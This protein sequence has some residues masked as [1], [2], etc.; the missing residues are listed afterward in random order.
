MEPKFKVEFLEDV[1]LFLD[2][3]DEK[4]RAKSFIIFGKREALMIKNFSKNYKVK[5]GSLELCSTKPIS[6]C[7]HFGIQQTKEIQL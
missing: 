3:L 5:F 2:E 7:L 4:A 1:K 6:V